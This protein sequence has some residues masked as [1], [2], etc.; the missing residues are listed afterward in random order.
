MVLL[1]VVDAEPGPDFWA[2]PVDCEQLAAELQLPVADLAEALRG[3]LTPWLAEDLELLLHDDAHDRAAD[4]SPAQIVADAV[5]A[6]YRGDLDA[7][8][9]SGR[10]VQA[11]VYAPEAS[12]LE[13]GA[14]LCA[15]LAAAVR[16]AGPHAVTEVREALGPFEAEELRLLSALPPLLEAAAVPEAEAAMDLVIASADRDEGV[17]A[18]V[19]V[20]AL[21][22]RR[23]FGTELPPEQVLARLEMVD[24]AGLLRLAR[25]WVDLALGAA[26]DTRWVTGLSERVRA[27]GRPGVLWLRSTASALASAAVGIAGR[28]VERLLPSLRDAQDAA[29][30]EVDARVRAGL[31]LARFVRTRAGIGP[32]SW[33]LLPPVA[34]ASA[35][36]GALLDGAEADSVVDLLVELLENDVESTDLLDGLVCATASLLV[37]LDPQQDEAARRLQVADLLSAV[38]GGPRGPRWLLGVLLRLAPGHD[39]LAVDLTAFLPQDRGVDPERA[40]DKLGL[41]GLVRAGLTCLQAMAEVLGEEADL[42][43]EELYRDVLPGALEEHQLLRQA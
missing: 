21:L 27:Q 14:R 12:Q 7:A 35:A 36:L 40:V 15:G 26:G 30:D 33:L 1:A 28:R 43:L 41:H 24:D 23:A 5:L 4:S 17:R 31:D 25:L 22:A 3:R 29:D 34:A 42:P 18:A 11:L 8:D 20:V 16:V 9:A 39:P 6:H 38:P 13:I 37:G 32:G 10:L 2:Q 19:R